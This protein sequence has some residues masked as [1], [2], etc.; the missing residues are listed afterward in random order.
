MLFKGINN[1]LDFSQSEGSALYNPLK[2]FSAWMSMLGSNLLG[3]LRVGPAGA[4]APWWADLGS[5]ASTRKY[6]QKHHWPKL[7]LL[8]PTAGPKSTSA[9]RGTIWGVFS[10]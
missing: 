8:G 6:F 1:I 4:R 7:A 9:Q 10:H 5:Q 3:S 2:L